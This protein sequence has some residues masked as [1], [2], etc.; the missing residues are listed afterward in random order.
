VGTTLWVLGRS[1]PESGDDYDHSAMFDASDR[2]DRICARIGVIPLSDFFD[3]T[4]FNANLGDSA[5]PDDAAMNA[6]ATWHDP[7]A[8]L[9]TLRALIAHLAT[10]PGDFGDDDDVEQL[11]EELEDCL[12]K[13]EDLALRREPFHL[14]VVM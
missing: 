10:H 13:V 2:L 7:A 9:P 14:C 12:G 11:G 8:A 1:K 4:D 5:F 6:S 3:W